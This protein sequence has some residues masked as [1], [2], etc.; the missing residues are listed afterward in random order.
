MSKMVYR[1][2]KDGHRY[3][4]KGDN[5]IDAQ[6]NAEIIFGV[7]LSRAMFEEIYK[8]KVIRQGIVR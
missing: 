7:K 3:S 2:T 5:R 4:V 1:F 6:A 8:G